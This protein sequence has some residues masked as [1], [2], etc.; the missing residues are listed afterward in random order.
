MIT[1]IIDELRLERGYGFINTDDHKRIFFHASQ[2]ERIRIDQLKEG[3]EMEF[4][5]REGQR[6]LEAYK[7]RRKEYRFLNPYNFAR[8][9]PEG[10][11]V[12]EGTQ[13]LGRC[14]PPAHDKFIGLSG[15]I[16]C[17][18]QTVT[19]LFIAGKQTED[20]I[21]HKTLEFFRVGDRPV[22]PASSLRG[23][24][25][26]LFETITNSCYVAFEYDEK[27]GSKDRLE[28]RYDRD[29]GLI[30]ARV[31]S[32]NE[33]GGELEVL[34]CRR[35][36]PDDL[37]SLP[38]T[39]VLRSALLKA[40][41]PQVL[42]NQGECFNNQLP[43]F[44]HDGLRVAALVYKN[45]KPHYR[46]NYPNYQYFVIKT[47]VPINEEKSLTE[48]EDSLKVFG[49]LK[50]TGPNIENKHDERLFFRWDD[51]NRATD[52]VPKQEISSESI[53]EYNRYLKKYWERHKDWIEELNKNGWLVDADSLPHPSN[54]IQEGRK[55]QVGDLVY[56]LDDPNAARIRLFPVCMPRVAYLNPRENL[57][58]PY[59]HA[60][61]EF[62]AL[63]PA[64]RM[65][66]WVAPQKG[67]TENVD[68]TI[69]AYAGRLCFSN[70]EIAEPAHWRIPNEKNPMVLSILGSP[71]PTTTPFYLLTSDDEAIYEIQLPN[72]KRP[73]KIDYD[74]DGV[75]LRGRKFYLH[76]GM[77]LFSKTFPNGEH[78]WEQTGR[79]SSKHNVSLQE[80]L[81]E[82]NII[83]FT[84]DFE[85][86][87]PVELGALLWTLKLENN[88]VHRLG[89]AKP[90]GFG[91]L[92]TTAIKLEKISHSARYKTFA[93]QGIQEISDVSWE[94][95]YIDIFKNAM[96]K[97]YGKD[98]GAL[99]NFEDLA[100]I[101][102]KEP[103]L[104]VHYP[105]LSRIPDPKGEQF[106]WFV[107]NK[108]Q[109]NA[110]PIAPDD[111]EGFRI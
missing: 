1:G 93:E 2:L 74:T 90:L 82:N 111:T 106:R 26:S 94:K 49:Y 33:S 3:D 70:G 37:E 30:P 59:L 92:K 68:K 9:L 62:N 88:W 98:F 14:R 8:F 69:N 109:K 44:A 56:F 5:V 41:P 25:R 24:V 58:P 22:I 57:L 66:G 12:D 54:F 20:E 110:L 46:G 99:K 78:E 108:R 11:A 42:T 102:G 63:C 65:F 96:K 17:T 60:C 15:K 18:M 75:K 67:K 83:T 81:S 104:P 77:E 103:Q 101:L 10:N 29:P 61:K 105:R 52:T 97:R 7:V 80:M 45:L 73:R 38:R 86:L 84:I 85:N 21:K 79:M 28:F 95:D 76:H 39:A 4:E 71:K 50:I 23:M 107:E 72:E 31:I 16:T 27:P 43:D 36:M 100:A 13:L 19:P 55:L 32:L 6:G 91:S 34:D 51:E 47:F 87:A 89:L 64:C 48:T 40:Y 53:G 35:K